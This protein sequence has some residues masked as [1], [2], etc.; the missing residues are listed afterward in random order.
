M[1][2]ETLLLILRALMAV[3]LYA[4]LGA[5]YIIASGLAFL[6]TSANPLIAVMGPAHNADRRLN[7]AQT[8]NPVG[9]MSGSFIGGLLIFSNVHYTPEQLAALSPEALDAFRATELEL[10][11]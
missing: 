1:P 7:F 8:F 10:E 2:I 3:A 9:T 11:V 6:E 5:L 4:F